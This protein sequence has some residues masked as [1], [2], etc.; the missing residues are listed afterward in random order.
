MSEGTVRGGIAW[1]KILSRI[2]SDEVRILRDRY[3]ENCPWR[4]RK[5]AEPFPYTTG[6]YQPTTAAER[7]NNG[8]KSV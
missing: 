6:N 3:K 5:G 4:H 1:E 8:K 2:L 7:S